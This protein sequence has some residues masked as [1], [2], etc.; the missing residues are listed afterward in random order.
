[1][2][3]LFDILG[4]FQ[5]FC[6]DA[7]RKYR[8]IGML[9]EKDLRVIWSKLT[10]ANTRPQKSQPGVMAVLDIILCKNKLLWCC[11]LNAESCVQPCA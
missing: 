9:I 2:I 7:S 4:D 10:V 3:F 1:M 11:F 8:I 6:G 5:D